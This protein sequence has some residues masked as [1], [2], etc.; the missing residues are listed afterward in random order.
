M[1]SKSKLEVVGKMSE[2][3]ADWTGIILAFSALIA[4]ILLGTAAILVAL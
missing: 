1:K 2:K 4:S 3:G